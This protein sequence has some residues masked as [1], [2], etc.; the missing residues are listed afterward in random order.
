MIV[1]GTADVFV[2]Q[3]GPVG[4]GP[5]AVLAVVEDGGDRGVGARAKR[6]CPGAGGIEAFRAGPVRNPVWRVGCS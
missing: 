3:A 2:E 4:L 1:V 6:Q 5:F